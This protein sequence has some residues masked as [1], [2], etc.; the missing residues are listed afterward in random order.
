[1]SLLDMGPYFRHIPQRLGQ[2][3]AL[4][5]AVRCICTVYKSTLTGNRSASALGRGDYY[6][7]LKSLRL[8]VLNPEEALSSNTLCAAVILSWYEVRVIPPTFLMIGVIK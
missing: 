6:K 1:M 5:D 2:N 7:A 8:S 4:D 3:Q